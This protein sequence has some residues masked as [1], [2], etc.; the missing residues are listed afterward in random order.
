MVEKSVPKAFQ[1]RVLLLFFWRNGQQ[2][3]GTDT[4]MDT[5][6]MGGIYLCRVIVN[7]DV[8]SR[9]SGARY[10]RWWRRRRSARH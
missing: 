8:A 7:R 1:V 4:K 5:E 2:Q 9:F 3:I 6:D 10:F